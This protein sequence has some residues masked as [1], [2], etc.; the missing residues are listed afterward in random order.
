[1]NMNA[2]PTM[3]TLGRLA[4]APLVA[5][6]ILWGDAIVFSQGARAAL[7]FFAIAL[8][9]FIAASVTD[10][11]DG[12]LAR[13][14]NATSDLGAALD[15]A[16]D[17]ALTTCTLVALAVTALTTDLVV[18][19]III[20]TRDVTIAGLREGMALSGR[21]LP[22]SSTGKLKTVVVLIGAGAA[23]AAQ[24]L[25]YAD[26]DVNLLRVVVLASHGALW[27][28]AALSLWSG[29]AY[30]VVAFKPNPS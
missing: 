28:G 9:L 12:I 8:V 7:V 22:V 25:V 1:M 6:L 21:A 26:A 16:A 2:L 15:H 20:L 29:W 11:L 27:A 10:A 5:G 23:L 14:L 13:K 4:A 24:T 19:V 17:K 18:A 30:G 3:L